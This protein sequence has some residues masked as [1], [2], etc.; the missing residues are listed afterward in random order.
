M[1]ETASAHEG[2]EL[3]RAKDFYVAATRKTFTE[4]LQPIQ[5][6]P[7]L[8]LSRQRLDSMKGTRRCPCKLGGPWW[9]A[10][11][12]RL[13]TRARLAQLG[14]E[15]NSQEG[16]DIYRINALTQTIKARQ[17]PAALRIK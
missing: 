7:E 17:Q 3:P 11:A 15:A 6:S 2:M 9:P 10:T 13:D 5:T 1:R 8:W 12:S 4:E 16:S 14:A